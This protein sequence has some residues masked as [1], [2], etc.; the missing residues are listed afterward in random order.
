[1]YIEVDLATL[2]ERISRRAAQGTDA[3]EANLHVLQHQI[4]TAQVLRADEL[5][6]VIRISGTAESTDLILN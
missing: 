6:V 1:M 4:E 2:R 5:N 3:S